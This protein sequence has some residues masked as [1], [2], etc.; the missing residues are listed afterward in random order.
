[1]SSSHV[2]TSNASLL[3]HLVDADANVQ[4]LFGGRA[5]FFARP[6]LQ[7]PLSHKD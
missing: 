7:E 3:P 6:E 4:V 2:F 5:G 1:V